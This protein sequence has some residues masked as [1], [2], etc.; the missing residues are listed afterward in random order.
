MKYIIITSISFLIL[1]SLSCKD[2]GVDPQDNYP[3]GYQHDIPWLS[4]ADSPWPM[5]NADPQATGRSKYLGPMNGIIDWE[6]VPV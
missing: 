6:F 2:K 1:I 5:H 3:P 4:L